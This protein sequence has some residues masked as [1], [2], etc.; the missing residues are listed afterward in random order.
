MILL[1]PSFLFSWLYKRH[2]GNWQIQPLLD[3]KIE[4]QCCCFYSPL[5]RF[6][7]NVLVAIRETGLEDDVELVPIFPFRN[8]CGDWIEGQ[9]DALSRNYAV[10]LARVGRPILQIKFLQPRKQH[11]V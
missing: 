2:G 3:E 7:H 1:L 8:V 10:H 9:Y 11:S 6:V 4:M 5:H